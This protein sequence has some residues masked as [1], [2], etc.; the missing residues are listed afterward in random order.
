M[1]TVAR[2]WR[3]A[4]SSSGASTRSTTSASTPHRRGPPPG[5]DLEPHPRPAERAPSVARGASASASPRSAAARAGGRRLGARGG[6]QRLEDPAHLLGAAGDRVVRA[7]GAPPATAR[8]AASSSTSADDP[9]QRRAQL[10]RE[11]GRQPLLVA[12]AGRDAVQQRVEGPRQ[13]AELVGPRLAGRSGARARARSTRPPSA[14]SPRPGRSARPIVSQVTRGH[15]GEQ[16]QARAPPSRRA[17]SRSCGRR[18]LERLRRRRRC[19]SCR[20]PRGERQRR[21]GATSWSPT[22]RN[23]AAAAGQRARRPAAASRCAGRPHARACPS[24]THT[25]AVDR[26]R[27]RATRAR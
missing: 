27:R 20:P 25:C 7:R 23:A 16:Q 22:S 19:P 13:L 17:R 18:R 2:A 8:G 24:K 3:P 5:L 15:G 1:R 9:R 11:L 4:L 21:T 10:V 14:S 6:H 12:Q 26:A